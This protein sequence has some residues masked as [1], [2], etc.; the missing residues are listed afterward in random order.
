MADNFSIKLTPK[1]KLKIDA[2]A[3]AG[4]VD[5]RPSLNVV[6][7]GYRKEVNMIFNRQ[8]PRGE[9]ARWPQLSPEYAAQKERQFPGS[10]IL[11]KTGALK[12]SMTSKGAPDNISLIAKTSAVFGSS[13]SYGI[14]HDEGGE[15]IPRRNFSEPS[16]RRMKI[17]IDQIE[18][19][20]IHNFEK[21]GIDVEGSI[22][23]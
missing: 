9:G 6:G 10:P 8:Q 4:K 22:I 5:L 13:I 12:S 11:V 14:Y 2:L 3:R 7:I 1:S 23:A 15:K 16:D 18:R 20:L 19:S 21:N 17:W